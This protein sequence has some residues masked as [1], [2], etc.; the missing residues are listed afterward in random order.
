MSQ[1]DKLDMLSIY[2]RCETIEIDS[3][4]L[5]IISDDFTNS[6]FMTILQK[7]MKA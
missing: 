5:T 1:A 6:D 4:T 2:G 3:D 7:I